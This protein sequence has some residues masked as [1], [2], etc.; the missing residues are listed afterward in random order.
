MSAG[1]R[2]SD[3]SDRD[4][5]R[6]Q[7]LAK[8]DQEWRA[9]CE[10]NSLRREVHDSLH[11]RGEWLAGYRRIDTDQLPLRFVALSWFMEPIIDNS[12]LAQ[13]VRGMQRQLERVSRSHENLRISTQREIGGLRNQLQDVQRRYNE[14]LVRYNQARDQHAREAT[15]WRRQMEELQQQN[16]QLLA[17]LRRYEPPSS[18]R[19]GQTC[20]RES[21]SAS[22]GRTHRDS[23]PGA[24][25]TPPRS[26]QPSRES[27]DSGYG[28]SM[29]SHSG[30]KRGSSSSWR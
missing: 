7:Q 11:L 4:D 23:V 16:Q 19:R 10:L 1:Y 9:R 20:G 3:S 8:V 29:D 18:H 14:L 2:N 5:A 17:R 27:H 25:Q 28:G 13:T 21:R 22:R 6:A 15:E 12:D 26:R 30:R 24:P